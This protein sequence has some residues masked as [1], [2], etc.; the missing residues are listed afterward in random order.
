MKGRL[1]FSIAMEMDP[2]IVLLDEV[3]SAG[4]AAFKDKV[5][6]LLA[7]FQRRGKTIV[8]VSHST[9]EIERTCDAAIWL[10]GGRVE[11]S[12]DPKEVV[13]RYLE[14]LQLKGSP[15]QVDGDDTQPRQPGLALSPLTDGSEKSR[16]RIGELK[17]DAGGADGFP[18]GDSETPIEIEGQIEITST[19]GAPKLGLELCNEEGRGIFAPPLIPLRA[20]GDGPLKPGE[21]PK[22]EV[23]IENVLA[24]GR[25]TLSC[26]IIHTTRKGR[27]RPVSAPRSVEF[28]LLGTPNGSQ[29]AVE[30]RHRANLKRGARAAA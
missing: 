30:L 27:D 23:A 16:A 13:G 17:I 26:A 28:A 21:T 18:A 11:A 3:L 2:D 6:N 12:G 20:Q 22:L 10:D 19:I 1:A 24:P 29:G 14:K 15:Q 9:G 25:Y 4:D 5:G 7:E 8:I